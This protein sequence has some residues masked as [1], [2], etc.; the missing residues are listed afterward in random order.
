MLSAMHH[1]G[2]DDSGTYHDDRVSIGMTR[3]SIIDTSKAGH[4]PMA[5]ND[6]KVVLVYNGETY[7]HAALRKNLENQGVL[8]RS[9]SD[10]EVVLQLYLKYGD[11][12][13]S[14]IRGMFALA[15]LDKRKG[16]GA[17]RMLLARDPMGIKPLIYARRGES[18]VF[19]SE[20]K[21][22]LA[23]GLIEPTINPLALHGLL[24]HGSVAQPDTII[25]NVHMLLPG[26]KLII[27]N[28]A[29]NTQQYWQL[30]TQ[31]QSDWGKASYP[32]Q[33]QQMRRLL[34][35]S[36]N[37]HMVSDLPVGAFLSGGVDSTILLGLMSSQSKKPV[38]TFSVGFGQENHSIDETNAAAKNAE[39]YGSDHSQ[40]L[41]TG[42][43]VRDSITDLA[44]ALDQPS[45][46]GANA[47]FVSSAVSNVVKVAVSGTGG[48]EP[49]AGYP[50]FQKM[51]G[52]ESGFG[53]GKPL[54]GLRRI[55]SEMVAPH[56]NRK[57]HDQVAGMLSRVRAS[58]DFL[59]AFS[60]QY[61]IFGSN[62]A[63]HLISP[64]LFDFESLIPDD[65]SRFVSADVLPDADVI[66]RV[67]ALCIRGYLQNQLLR[68]VDSV[69]MAHSLEVRVPYL[70]TEII[71]FALAL[72]DSSKSGDGKIINE[73]Y[74]ETGA[75]RILLDAT[76]DLIPQGLQ[77][78]TKSGF[79]MPMDSWLKGPLREIL[80]D[81][82]SHTAVSS[83][84]LFS[85]SV[86]ADMRKAFLNGKCGWSFPWIIMITEL[87]CREVLDGLPNQGVS[88]SHV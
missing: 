72:P 39:F 59:E 52:L 24:A 50:W 42:T 38:H 57:H 31:R 58:G 68:D 69:S 83:R 55:L 78:Q 21:A 88:G 22:L 5:S 56:L 9:T 66:S 23:S 14:H 87:W 2:P 46:D 43:D 73:S 20:I 28:G 35:D 47:Y 51:A 8:F 16:K 76:R 77:E 17:E 1:R 86:V 34:E 61:R 25:E 33:V 63:A 71:D 67:S 19:A 30:S 79:A 45:V 62:R 49:F 84:G 81:S 4:Q 64:E 60:R 32:E 36:V 26:H 74:K 65:R 11:N 27:D 40:V 75:K 29:I 10:T 53:K 85:P 7:N 12:F 44:S 70:D 80:E 82:T 48:D 18:L 15:I 41:V 37:M 3:L 13:L 54:S 6:G